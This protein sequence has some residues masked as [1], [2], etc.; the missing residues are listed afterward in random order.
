MNTGTLKILLVVATFTAAAV[1][2][3]VA[4]G[5]ERTLSR[6]QSADISGSE[7]CDSERTAERVRASDGVLL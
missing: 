2:G 6:V 1:A 5:L 4:A 3:P 7:F